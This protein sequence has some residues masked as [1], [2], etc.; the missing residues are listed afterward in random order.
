[1]AGF[2]FMLADQCLIII[3]SQNFHLTNLVTLKLIYILTS[4]KHHGFSSRVGLS[5]VSNSVLIGN[6][7]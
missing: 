4:M 2:L 3:K 1:M 5:E 7:I 6:E